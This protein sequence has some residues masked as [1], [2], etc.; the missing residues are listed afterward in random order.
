M[1]DSC[2]KHNRQKEHALIRAVIRPVTVTCRPV[3]G[4]MAMFL[5]NGLSA[6]VCF[7]LVFHSLCVDVSTPE[8]RIEAVLMPHA[9]SAELKC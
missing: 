3:V 2:C 7:S 8:W 5:I 9:T 1:I 6:T 4:Q